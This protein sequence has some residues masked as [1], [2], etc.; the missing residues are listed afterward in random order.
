MT[1]QESATCPMC[2]ASIG[3]DDGCPDCGESAPSPPTVA[4]P[5]R[6]AVAIWNWS[7][8]IFFSVVSINAVI[9]L[10]TIRGPQLWGALAALILSLWVIVLCIRDI[11]QRNDG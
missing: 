1:K 7:L 5:R 6:I 8:L 10:P 11:F 2:G 4:K 3:G 9:R